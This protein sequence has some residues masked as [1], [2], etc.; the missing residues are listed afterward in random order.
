MKII[1]NFKDYYDHGLIYGIDDNNNLTYYKDSIG[2]WKKWK[3][4]EHNNLIEYMD[5]DYIPIENVLEVKW[6]RQEYEIWLYIQF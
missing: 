3:Y 2:N 1:S 4:D 6:R 5:S